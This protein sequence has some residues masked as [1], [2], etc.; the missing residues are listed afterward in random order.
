MMKATKPERGDYLR[1]IV[2]ILIY[3]VLIGG[4]AFLLLP[5][6]WVLW[7]I[8]VLGGLILLVSWHR[9][10]TVYEC[11]NCAHLYEISFWVDLVSP[12]G[13]DGE[14]GWLWLRC[15]SC[16]QRHKTRVLKRVD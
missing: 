3:V 7:G 15:P 5:R 8:I 16:K 11:P 9:G 1:S 2:Y 6:Y 13:V 10:Q 12:H 14:G 4:G